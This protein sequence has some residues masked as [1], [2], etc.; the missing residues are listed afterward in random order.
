[1]GLTA[2]MDEMDEPT[3]FPFYFVCFNFGLHMVVMIGFFAPFFNAGKGLLWDKSGWLLTNFV[4]AFLSWYYFYK[5]VKTKPGYL[6]NSLPDIAKWRRLYEETLESYA[7]EN[8]HEKSQMQL[9]HTC[10]VAR[11]LRAK[12]CRVHRKC[13]LLFDHFCPFVDNTIGLYNYK[14]FYTFLVFMTLA[15]LF[16]G[17]T[18]YL[19]QK[20]YYAEHGSMDW[21]VLCLGIEVVM[22]VIPIGGMCI[23]H[24]Q[25]AMVNLS[26]NEHL[27]VRKYKYLYPVVN[28]KRQYKNPWFKGYWGNF[29]DRMNP[30]SACYEVP[31]D[32]ESLISGIARCE[33][34]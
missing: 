26:T 5:T 20:R 17:I 13:V 19:Y 9:C 23:Y 21:L 32:H 34:V 25:L 8:A 33:T 6:D 18:L 29:M 16:F 28:G 12:H 3:K 1:M 22:N 2:G 27:N 10:H 30:S 14:Y 11:P 4:L 15:E 31:S 24:T 7:D